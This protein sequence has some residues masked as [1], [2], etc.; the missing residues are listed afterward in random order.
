MDI[1]DI[2]YVAI[3][4]LIAISGIIGLIIALIR[5]EIK[6]FVIKEM[7]KAEA[8]YKDL[9]KPE[10]SKKK[11]QYVLEQVNAHYGITQK[12]INIKKFIEQIVELI[13]GF[14]TK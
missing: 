7:E 11:L 4:G 2:V 6:D 8:L 13:N 12:F 3:L 9:P 14:K 1:K 10:K 5:G